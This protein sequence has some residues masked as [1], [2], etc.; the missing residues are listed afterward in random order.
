MGMCEGGLCDAGMFVAYNLCLEGASL[1]PRSRVLTC[2]ALYRPKSNV[3]ERYNC[4][5]YVGA[6][7]VIE[8]C[9]AEAR[10]GYH[11]GDIPVCPPVMPNSAMPHS[12]MPLTMGRGNGID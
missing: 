10:L 3:Q 1:C 2:I 12:A 7:P 9:K 6:P 4:V 11:I 5:S 8:Q